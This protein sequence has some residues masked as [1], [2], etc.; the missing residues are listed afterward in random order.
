MEYLKYDPAIH[1]LGCEFR[2]VKRL[3]I[4]LNLPGLGPAYLQDGDLAAIDIAYF[5][6][7]NFDLRKV[8]ATHQTDRLGVL[9]DKG[10]MVD[11]Y[12]VGMPLNYGEISFQFSDLRIA[13]H[14]AQD[15]GSGLIGHSQKM[16]VAARATA[17]KKTVGHRS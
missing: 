5:R 14:I 17:E 3:N 15:L 12:E 13:T 16:T 6:F 11:V 10:D 2:F 1:V 9:L 8:G 4:R 7:E